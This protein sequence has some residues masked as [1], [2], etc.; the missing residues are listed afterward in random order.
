MSDAPAVRC[1]AVVAAVITLASFST[2][3]RTLPPGVRMEGAREQVEVRNTLPTL[4]QSLE[5]GQPLLETW[6]AYESSHEKLLR[7]AG[8]EPRD[9]GDPVLHKLAA[10]PEAI[11][12]LLKPVSAR[13]PDETR[14]QLAV[15]ETRLGPM[16]PLVIAFGA[17]R[18]LQPVFGARLDDR[19]LIFLNARDP[20]LA[21]EAPRQAIIARELFSAW[22]RE[23]TPGGDQLGPLARRVYREGAAHF[24]ART[25]VPDL[26]ETDLFGMDERRL[27]ALRA[28]QAL[29]ARELLAGLESSSEAEA[30]RF[31]SDDVRDPLLPPGAGPFIAER[32][33]QR[34]AADLGSLDRPLQLSPDEF[35]QR[36]RPAL[37]AL[38]SAK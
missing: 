36:A 31:F 24:A 2:G 15:L 25:T 38:A 6:L 18:T 29:I 37:Q 1:I 21:Q 20:H 33:Y 8:A 19:P 16:P 26:R 4:V 27:V 3:C 12:A 30:A 22:Q 9:P 5:A 32:L 13:G 10:S 35:L 28:R 7:A 14:A 23:R 11:L 17:S 34:L